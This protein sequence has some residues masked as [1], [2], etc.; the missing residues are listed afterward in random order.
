MKANA[1]SKD[2][3]NVAIEKYKDHPINK[4]INENVS[5]ESRFSFTE[6]R[7]SERKTRFLILTPRNRG[8]SEIFLRK[9]LRILPIFVTLYFKI[10]GIMKY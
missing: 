5:F 7:E 2:S 9:Y 10:Y 8:L 4:M 3:V 1:R 6:I